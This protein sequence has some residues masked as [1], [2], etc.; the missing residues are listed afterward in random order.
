MNKFGIY[1]WPAYANKKDNPY[2]YLIYRHIEEEGYPVY[3]LS[4]YK[5][6][7][8][9]K[10]A[11]SSKYKVLH[12]HWPST[13]VL[14]ADTVVAAWRRLLSFYF[15]IKIIK[16]SGKKI[17]WTVHNLEVHEN[18]YANLQKYMNKILYNNVDGFISMNKLGID[19]IGKKLKFGNKQKISYIPHPHYKFYYPNKLTSEQARKELDIDNKTFVFVFIGK[20]RAYKNLPALI[21]AF[22]NLNDRN[23]LLLIAG[24]VC[25]DV[26]LQSLNEQIG[27]TPN[28]R[29]Y[30]SFIE[31][32]NLQVFLN[33]ADLVVTPYSKIFNSGSVFLNLS[34]NK[35]TL[36]P[37]LYALSELKDG[38]G[39]YWIKTYKGDLTDE[40]LKRTMRQVLREKYKALEPDIDIHDPEMIAK[41]TISFYESLCN[42]SPDYISKMKLASMKK[43]SIHG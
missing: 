4:H 18:T 38:L 31:D 41:H 34:F 42:S 27:E 29:L 13:H 23:T 33:A 9:V 25:N 8:L 40:V 35:P 39:T 5:K 3:D 32:D 14:K 21:S 30:N 12:I 43:L 10:I 36:V 20:I 7:L 11:L 24:K 2:N 16:L 19:L 28:V 15:F 22:I 6:N 26:L 17:V 1:A 37:D